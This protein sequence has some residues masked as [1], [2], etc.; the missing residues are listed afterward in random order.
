MRLRSAALFAV[1]VILIILVSC[2]LTETAP[3]Y[4]D[5]EIEVTLNYVLTGAND[6]AVSYMFQDLNELKENMI[7]EQYGAMDEFRSEIPGMDMLLTDW[8]TYTTA[9]IIPMF[10]DFTT[11]TLQ[12]TEAQKFAD[13]RTLLNSGTSSVSL[14][15][16]RLH[17]NEITQTIRQSITGMDLSYW[18]M[19]LI[20]YNAWVNTRAVLSGQEAKPL[21][22][23]LSDD[24]FLDIIASHL[25]DLYFK[26]L[27]SAEILIRTTPDPDM[28]QTAARVLGLV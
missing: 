9:F 26:H 14:Y 8:A 23:N 22:S 17:L 15:M 7:P 4:S 25:A 19:A 21:P 18:R 1:I 20:Q 10:D 16:R 13:P 12:I 3:V 27:S 11:Y 24:A 28:D 2:K 6:E 5:E